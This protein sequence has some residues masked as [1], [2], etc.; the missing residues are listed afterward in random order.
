MQLFKQMDSGIWGYPVRTESETPRTDAF[1]A[2]V[3]EQKVTLGKEHYDQALEFARTIEYE[4]REET[5]R[6]EHYKALAERLAKDAA[7]ALNDQAER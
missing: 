5:Y 3:A 6:K 7:L 1:Q 4:L 2:S